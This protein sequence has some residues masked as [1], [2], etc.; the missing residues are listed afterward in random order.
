MLTGQLKNLTRE[1]FN[2]HIVSDSKSIFRAVMIFVIEEFGS[3]PSS[4]RTLPAQASPERRGN[5]THLAPQLITAL[6]YT[7]SID[8]VVLC[9]RA[10]KRRMRHRCHPGVVG[11]SST[12]FAAGTEMSW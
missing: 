7:E 5:V 1:Q 12:P 3:C 11:S 2:T 4:R 10:T 8:S 6:H 9:G